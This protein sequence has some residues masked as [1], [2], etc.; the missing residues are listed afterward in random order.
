MGVVDRWSL[1]RGL[2]CCKNLPCDA[3]CWSLKQMTAIWGGLLLKLVCMHFFANLSDNNNLKARRAVSQTNIHEDVKSIWS[4]QRVKAVVAIS[5]YLLIIVS[6]TRIFENFFGY[7]NFP[8]TKF[9][10]DLSKPSIHCILFCT[11]FC[12]L[13]LYL[14]KVILIRFQTEDITVYY[15]INGNNAPS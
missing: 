12:Q 6:V 5:G 8:G 2:Y 11:I 13:V 1:F 10:L 15:N 3:K 14:I 7:L 4:L 9:F